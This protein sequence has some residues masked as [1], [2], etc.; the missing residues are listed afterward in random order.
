M[1]IIITDKQ[2]ERFADH[3]LTLEANRQS[4]ARLGQEDKARRGLTMLSDMLY[5]ARFFGID[6]PVVYKDGQYIRRE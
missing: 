6:I 2:I 1:P 4:Y 5:T 3:F